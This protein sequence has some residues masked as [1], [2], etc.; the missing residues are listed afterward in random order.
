[1]KNK[2]TTIALSRGQNDFGRATVPVNGLAAGVRNGANLLHSVNRA[3]TF[4]FL[5]GSRTHEPKYAG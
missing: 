2:K 1:M 5:K 3:R 4:S